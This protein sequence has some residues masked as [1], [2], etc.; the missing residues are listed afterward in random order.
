DLAQVARLAMGHMLKERPDAPAPHRIYKAKQEILDQKKLGRSVAGR[1]DPVTRRAFRW[2]I[3]SLD[4]PPPDGCHPLAD[5]LASGPV[6]AHNLWESPVEEEALGRILY[7]TLRDLLTPREDVLLALLLL[8][9]YG[10][11][12][13]GHL[14]ELTRQQTFRTQQAIQVKA[15]VLLG[16]DGERPPPSARQRA[17]RTAA[18]ARWAR[19][20]PFVAPATVQALLAWLMEPSE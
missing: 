15:A 8:L 11:K 19:H 16:L 5:S 13:A 12:G 3:V 7:Q 4:A 2:L 17:A 10:P 20:D 9:G 18:V 6:H 1:L 14:L